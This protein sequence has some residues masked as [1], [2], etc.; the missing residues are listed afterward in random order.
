MQ[1]K[2]VTYERLLNRGKFENT[3]LSVTIDLD[4]GDS[5]EEVC[6][7]AKSMVIKRLL[8]EKSV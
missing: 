6:K 3:R 7:T 1:V 4:P 8:K 5:F 2:S